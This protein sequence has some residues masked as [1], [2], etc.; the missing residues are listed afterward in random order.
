[1]KYTEA[2]PRIWFE[3]GHEPGEFYHAADLG[4]HTFFCTDTTP[5]QHLRE[6]Y[7]VGWFGSIW[8]DNRGPC[9]VR[10]LAEGSFPDAQLRANG[11]HL[12]LEVTM[13]LAKDKQMFKEWRE[14]RAKTER[15]E[16]VLAESPEECQAS[17]REAIP[18]VVGRKANKHYSASARTTLLVSTNTALSAEELAR[19]T[20]PWRERFDAIYFIC[21]IDVVMAWPTRTILRG[22]WPLLEARP[23]IGSR[24]PEIDASEQYLT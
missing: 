5:P 8:R 2:R 4:L 18:R 23:T 9:E 20:E 3:E 15:G 22:Q 11:T 12:N 14:L 21:G 7:L 10:L 19:L 13:A 6:A 24:H 1:M 17:A 16:L